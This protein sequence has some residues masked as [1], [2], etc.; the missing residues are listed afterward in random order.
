M[1]YP[2][3]L[4]YRQFF[5]AP[6]IDLS[7]IHTNSRTVKSILKALNFLKTPSPALEYNRNDGLKLHLI[8]F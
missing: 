1:I 4:R 2:D 8:F 5:L 7:K 6:D 3:P